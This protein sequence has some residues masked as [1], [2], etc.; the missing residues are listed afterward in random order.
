M[1]S[2]FLVCGLLA[3]EWT[4]TQ[5]D[6][7]AGSAGLM[8]SIEVECCTDNFRPRVDPIQTKPL[9]PVGILPGTNA[10]AIT[11]SCHS[12]IG[13]DNRLKAGHG[14]CRIASVEVVPERAC[15][16]NWFIRRAKR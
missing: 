12:P 6:F 1:V 3:D 16:A 2:Y 14:L 10:P 15:G 5:N 8:S 7:A 11:K 9:I 4:S 13:G